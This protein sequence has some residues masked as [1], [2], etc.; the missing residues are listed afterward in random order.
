MRPPRKRRDRDAKWIQ[1]LR[2]K[3]GPPVFRRPKADHDKPE[4]K[5][6]T[7]R[8][9]RCRPTDRTRRWLGANGRLLEPSQPTLGSIGSVGLAPM[10]HGRLIG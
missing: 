4:P 6:E 9:R 5:A 2:A 1:E 7:L 10:G 3:Y 8:N